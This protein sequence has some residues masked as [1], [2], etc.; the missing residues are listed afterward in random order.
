[1]VLS[2]LVVVHDTLV[3]GEDNVAKLSGWEDIVDELLEVLE[4]EVES[5]GDDTALVKSSVEVNDDLAGSTVINDLEFVDVS[6]LLHLSEE[7]DDDLG[8]W[9]K[10]NLN[11]YQNK[12]LKEKPHLASE[13][14]PNLF[15]WHPS[16]SI[17]ESADKTNSNS[18][19]PT[20]IGLLT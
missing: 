13:E 2:G 16:S 10:E 3:G 4:L 6:V 20:T 19:S 15:R 8:H 14:A 9:S 17:T 1:M 5:W 11:S 12:N 7:L 18:F